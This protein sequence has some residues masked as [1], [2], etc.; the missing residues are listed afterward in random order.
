M[1]QETDIQEIRRLVAMNDETYRMNPELYRVAT[2]LLS[3]VDALQT[4]NAKLREAL[5]DAAGT[6]N[7]LPE[8][9]NIVPFVFETI[10]EAEKQARAALKGDNE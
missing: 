5:G 9:I 3:E 2:T 8:I 6:F 10:V 4:E 1:T 7:A